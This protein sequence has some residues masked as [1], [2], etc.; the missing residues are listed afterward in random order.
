MFDVKALLFVPI[1]IKQTYTAGR[2]A[3]IIDG[4]CRMQ[5]GRRVEISALLL[6]LLLLRISRGA[7]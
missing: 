4:P 3:Q 2:R 7:R 6:L 5:V 1:A